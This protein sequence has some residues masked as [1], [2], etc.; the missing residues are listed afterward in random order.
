MHTET[1]VVSQATDVSHLS[2]KDVLEAI[3]SS[4]PSSGA[5]I[6]A[7]LALA[8]A[9]ACALK[10][11]NITLKHTPDAELQ[12]RSARLEA[13]RDRALDRAR[14][15]AHLFGKYLEDHEPRDAA[16]LV[17]AAAEFQALAREIAAELDHLDEK[18]RA[19]V[20]ADVTAARTL[21]AAAVTIEGLIMRD[22]RKLRARTMP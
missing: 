7:A 4:E 12:Q 22:S 10:A 3:G 6:S 21:H 11:V 8:L 17:E 18:V 19:S 1:A 13:Q 5:G 20:V 9:T 15:D 2:V 14:A 16:L